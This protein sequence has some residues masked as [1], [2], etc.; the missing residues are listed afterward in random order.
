M[1]SRRSVLL[2]ASGV[3]AT[4]VRVPSGTATAKDNVLPSQQLVSNRD[5]QRLLAAEQCLECSAVCARR[6]SELQSEERQLADDCRDICNVTATVLS[7]S[8]PAAQ[9]ISQACADACNRFQRVLRRSDASPAVA[10]C[11]AALQECS[12]ACLAVILRPV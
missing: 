5:K 6:G 7:R 4:G 9:A 10:E 1:L 11:L 12:S 8:G 2:A 3:V